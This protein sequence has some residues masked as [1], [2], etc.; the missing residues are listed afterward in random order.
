MANRRW[1]GPL[2][3][4]MIV[5]STARRIAMAS[6]SVGAR[7]RPGSVGDLVLGSWPRTF[8]AAAL[9]ALVVVAGVWAY[10]SGSLASLRYASFPGH[11]YPP[12]GYYQNPFNAKDRGDLINAADAG[13]VKSDLLRDGD[14]ELQAVASGT[15]AGLVEADSGNRL[16]R[17]Q[18]VVHDYNA[19]GLTVRQET[20]FDAILVGHLSDP[21][22]PAVT[23]CVQE[24]GNATITYVAT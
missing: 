17:L 15:E 11:P 12:A 3:L 5:P 1:I 18:E 19:A 8:A 6:G 16:A 20:H 10:A 21:N 13:R 4:T 2:G 22:S 14:I 23:W 7:R 9:V 24:K